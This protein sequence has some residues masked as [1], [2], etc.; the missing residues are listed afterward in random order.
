MKV[1]GKHARGDFI[2][3][4]TLR[5]ERFG[6]KGL[7]VPASERIEHLRDAA[8]ADEH[9]VA[10]VLGQQVALAVDDRL[11]LA[12]TRFRGFFVQHV[13]IR[14]RDEAH[15]LLAQHRA[16]AQ[17]NEMSPGGATAVDHYL[18][19]EGFSAAHYRWSEDAAQ[20]DFVARASRLQRN[21]EDF[22]S[23]GTSR[24]ACGARAAGS[25]ASVAQQHHPTPLLGV[26]GAHGRLE[27]AADVG[28]ALRNVHAQVA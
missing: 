6:K 5:L 1:G 12:Q 26:E 11:V 14:S 23:E 10:V 15:F 18:H 27:P 3:H 22:H 7:D 17:Q 4:E 19:L 25:L 8:H 24:H 21:S 9:L 28:C 2:H 13:A 20:P 16:V